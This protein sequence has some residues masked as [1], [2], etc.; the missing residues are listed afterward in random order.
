MTLSEGVTRWVRI[1]VELLRI[2]WDVDRHGGGPSDELGS[3]RI[4]GGHTGVS[5]DTLVKGE[6]V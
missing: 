2:G 4:S 6:V 3:D 5:E 1:G